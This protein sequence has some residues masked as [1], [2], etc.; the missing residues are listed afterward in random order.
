MNNLPSPHQQT[1]QTRN[2]ARHH[3]QVQSKQNRNRGFFNM[4]ITLKVIPLPTGDET[5]Y[6]RMPGQSDNSAV[7]FSQLYNQTS[8]WPKPFLVPHFN[9]A[10]NSA[11]LAPLGSS[12]LY[13]G[14][15][16][17]RALQ[18]K[19]WENERWSKTVKTFFI[20]STIAKELI[21]AFTIIFRLT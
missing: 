8:A 10:I 4:M 21:M 2:W 6:I 11:D 12:I 5:D 9:N 7:C 16:P 19:S 15:A 1:R 3:H 18:K 17:T 13:K 14:A 20:F